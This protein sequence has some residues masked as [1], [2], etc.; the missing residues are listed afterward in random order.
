LGRI[1]ARGQVVSIEPLVQPSDDVG[2]QWMGPV[3]RPAHHVLN[4]QISF[5]DTEFERNDPLVT[6]R[7]ELADGTTAVAGAGSPQSHRQHWSRP[8][9]TAT[10][11]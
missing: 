1:G 9:T 3:R 7:K 2:G 6:P 5:S 4:R 11:G 10:D 8:T